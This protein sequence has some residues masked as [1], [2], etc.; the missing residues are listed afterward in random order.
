[1]WGVL[2]ANASFGNK[3]HRTSEVYV[4]TAHNKATNQQTLSISGQVLGMVSKK[5][6][7]AKVHFFELKGK[8]RTTKVRTTKD[9]KFTF[10]NID[11]TVPIQLIAQSIGAK[12]LPMITLDS[13]RVRFARVTLEYK[14][15]CGITYRLPD[16]YGDAMRQSPNGGLDFSQMN[17]FK[18]RKTRRDQP[19]DVKQL[20]PKSLYDFHKEY[21]KANLAVVIPKDKQYVV[22]G[23]PITAPD[24]LRHL[25]PQEIKSIFEERSTGNTLLTGRVLIKTKNSFSLSRISHQQ[26]E[27]F[28]LVY[29]SPD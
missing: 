18:K 26:M 8:R 7:R 21:K 13:D 12:E 2:G 17:L 14:P 20:N 3:K 19:L 9:G 24:V 1:M 25:N 6:I 28:A 22:N 11:P 5:P 29:I 15:G 4:L 10:V 27:E 16:D 23:V